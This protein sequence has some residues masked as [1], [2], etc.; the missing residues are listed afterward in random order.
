M[1]N[2]QRFSKTSARTLDFEARFNQ[3]RAAQ[4]H[5]EWERTGSQYAKDC[6]ANYARVARQCLFAMIA[7]NARYVEAC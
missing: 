5:A 4:C 1:T 6:A 7:P 3:R 2:A